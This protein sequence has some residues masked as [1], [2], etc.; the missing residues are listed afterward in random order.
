MRTLEDEDGHHLGFTGIK[1]SPNMTHLGVFLLSVMTTE[2]WC[3]LHIYLSLHVFNT[4]FYGSYWLFT[5]H[6]ID[7]S[8]EREGYSLVWPLLL[9]GNCRK[10]SKQKKHSCKSRGII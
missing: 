8:R 5:I 6:D 3:V 2:W 1:M 4:D 10:H 9:I 7:Q